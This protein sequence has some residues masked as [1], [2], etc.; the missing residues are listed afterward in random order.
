VVGITELEVDPE[1]R[2][3]K[4]TSVDDSR[5]LQPDLKAALVGA[6]ISP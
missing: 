4:L 1:G 5:Q 2:M 6:S 3:T